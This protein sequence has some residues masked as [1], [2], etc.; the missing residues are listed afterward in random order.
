MIQRIQS[1][2]LFLAGA[3]MLATGFLPLAH[4]DKGEGFYAMTAWA[5]S[6][7]SLP[8]HVGTPSMPYG[9]LFFTALT[10]VMLWYTIFKFKNRKKQMRLCCYACTA[11]VLYYATAAAYALAFAANV[12]AA[13]WMPAPAMLL[14]LLSLLLTIAARRGVKHDEE[15]V[16]AADRIR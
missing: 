6:A 13:S 14:P 16:R 9:M 15:L 8:P 5:F 4:F 7:N 10:V 11:I 2:Y 3:L 12:G 1:L